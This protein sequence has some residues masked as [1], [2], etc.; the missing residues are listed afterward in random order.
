MKSSFAPLVALFA[1][2]PLVAGHG[3]VDSVTIDGKKY[4]GNMPTDHTGGTTGTQN[5]TL[6]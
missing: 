3:W 1:V 2:V 4:D 5:T 6:R